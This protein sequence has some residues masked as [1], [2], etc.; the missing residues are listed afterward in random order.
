VIEGY[1]E[2]IFEQKYAQPFMDIKSLNI[3]LSKKEKYKKLLK[4]CY[5]YSGKSHHPS[6]HNAIF[7]VKKG[8]AIL[9]G[10][11]SLPLEL[12]KKGKIWRGKQTPLS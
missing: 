2:N 5:E 6:T 12:K 8:K 11:T 7:L 3:K 9:K 4:S 1:R 10:T